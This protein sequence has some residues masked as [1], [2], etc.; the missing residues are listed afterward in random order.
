MFDMLKEFM[1]MMKVKNNIGR[2]R[3]IKDTLKQ[4]KL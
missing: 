1:Y 4:I 3:Y 2:W